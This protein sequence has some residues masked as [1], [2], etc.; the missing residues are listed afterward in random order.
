[1]SVPAT[2]PAPVQPSSEVHLIQLNPQIAE[3]RGPFDRPVRSQHKVKNIG[4]SRLVIKVI[5][6]DS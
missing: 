2:T 3:F 6:G 1:M 5:I 4:Q